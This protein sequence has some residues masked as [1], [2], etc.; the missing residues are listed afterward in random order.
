MASKLGQKKQAALAALLAQP[1]ITK[2][3]AAVGVTEK[4]L[5]AWLKDADFAREYRALRS[6]IVEHALGLVQKSTARAAATLRSNLKAARPADQIRAATAILR[7]AL[8]GLEVG[9]ILE[10]LEALEAAQR[11]KKEIKPTCQLLN[12]D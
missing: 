10:R 11:V 7:A 2:A 12:G 8:Q 6:Q 3:A 4:T 9:D 1:S 5:R